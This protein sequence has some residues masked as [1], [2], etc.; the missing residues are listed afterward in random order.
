M[1][2]PRFHSKR[3][4]TLIELL[5][6][7]GII[8]LLAAFGV[9]AIGK[10]QE[11]GK[12]AK[13]I[14]NIRQVGGALIQFAQDNGGMLPP[15]TKESPTEPGKGG[16]IWP[17]ILWRDGYLLESDPYQG[18]RHPPCGNGIWTCPKTP[19]VSDAYGGYGVCEP[20]VFNGWKDKNGTNGKL[21]SLRLGDITKPSRTWLVGDAARIPDENYK[22]PWYCIWPEPARW[23]SDHGPGFRHVGGKAN[24][25]MADGHIESLTKKAM[26]DNNYTQPALLQ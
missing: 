21:G 20:T 15:V 8:I 10:M 14:S 6:V 4:F 25:M 18:Q 17:M 7:I 22:Y 16:D 26:T 24:A 2:N 13:C 1:T 3:G 23:A 19:W 5:V 12:S 9:P 11:S